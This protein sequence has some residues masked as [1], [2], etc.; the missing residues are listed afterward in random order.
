MRARFLTPGRG[1]SRLVDTRRAGLAGFAGAGGADG[2]VAGLAVGGYL[3]REVE[4]G[5]GG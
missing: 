3:G 4:V 1:G 5:A 2:G